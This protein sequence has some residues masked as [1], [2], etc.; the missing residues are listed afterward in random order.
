M[1]ALTEIRSQKLSFTGLSRQ[2]DRWGVG[3]V[4]TNTIVKRKYVL[5]NFDEYLYQELLT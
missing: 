5:S 3:G 1:L 2:K 4:P